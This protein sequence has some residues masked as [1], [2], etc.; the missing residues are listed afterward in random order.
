MTDHI[1]SSR[2]LVLIGAALLVA[3]A[4]AQVL[5]VIPPFR[6]DTFPGVD[7]DRN[8]R[9]E[10]VQP[11]MA[12]L[13]ALA[14]MVVTARAT[15]RSRVRIGVLFALGALVFLLGI[16]LAGLAPALLVHGPHLR[17]AIFIMFLCGLAH[18]IAAGLVVAGASRLPGPAMSADTS[19]WTSRIAPAVLLGI[20]SFLLAWLLGEGL[21]FLD[22]VR[23]GE[24]VTA[25]VVAVALGGYSLLVTW[26][27]L[28]GLPPAG[29]NLWIVLAMNAALLLATLLVLFAGPDS[30]KMALQLLGIVLFSSAGSYGGL[31]LAARARKPR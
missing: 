22:A 17:V 27:L 7:L 31:A 29:R 3:A 4:V 14:L 13:L 21:G 18:F 30:T 24:W 10:M 12:V 16:P 20:G 26:A 5:G 1:G 19:A 25:L 11:G 23:A 8:R 2:R 9:T 28:R 6:H 15:G